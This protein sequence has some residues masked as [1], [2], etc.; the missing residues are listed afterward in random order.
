MTPFWQLA[1]GGKKWTVHPDFEKM[2]LGVF[3]KFGS[4]QANPRHPQL[5]LKAAS[6]RI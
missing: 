3:T 2:P 6:F 4:G 5:P 1:E